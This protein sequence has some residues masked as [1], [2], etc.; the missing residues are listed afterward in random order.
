MEKQEDKDDVYKTIFSEE[1]RAVTVG[2]SVV[3]Y[4][5]ERLIG[6]GVVI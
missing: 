5:G 3:W 6:G 4:S 1:Q 2:Q